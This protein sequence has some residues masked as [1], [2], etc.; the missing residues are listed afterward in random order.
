MAGIY[1]HIPFCL[2]ACDYCDFYSVTN[3]THLL[4]DF[5]RAICAEIKHRNRELSGE[6]I[7]TIYFGGGTPSMISPGQLEE[8]LLSVFRCYTVSPEAEITIEA[9]PDD[10]SDSW[11]EALIA[12]GFNRISIGTQ[13]FSDGALKFLNRRH[14]ASRA[15]EAIRISAN[16]GFQ[17]ISADLIYGIPGYTDGLLYNDLIF[18]VNSEVQHISVYALTVEHNTPLH[19][20]I[21]RGQKQC[22]DED[23]QSGQYLII[24]DFLESN[25][26]DG[27]EISNFALPG[28]RS[29]HNSAYWEAIPYLGFGPAAHSFHFN[30]R[31][32]N[33]PSLVDY[34]RRAD[35]LTF[36]TLSEK[37]S[38]TDMYNE[39]VMTALRTKSGL[40]RSRLKQF[41]TGTFEIKANQALRKFEQAGWIQLQ[42]ESICLTRE[43]KLFADRISRELFLEND[44]Q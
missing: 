13:S 16:A 3:K 26:Y 24:H 43:G 40:K 11:C 10:I 28:F 5:V 20:K 18:F 1:I 21:S 12:M 41:L 39:Y 2:T 23:V 33:A 35:S 38:L 32:Y 44:S 4:P 27:Y 15:R 36:R 14:N 19:R 34:I 17:N 22:P 9:N 30:E 25:G 6:I 37:L 7:N 42:P 31:R 29:R 8:I